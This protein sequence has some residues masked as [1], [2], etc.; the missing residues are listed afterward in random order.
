MPAFSTMSTTVRAGAVE[1][2]FGHD[3]ALSGV[4]GHGSILE[5]DEKLALDHI[6]E[7]I[8]VIVF[9]PVIF[10]V[11]N[12]EANYRGVYLAKRLV[13]PLEL[14]GIGELLF[15]NDLEG[16]VINVQ[17]SFVGIRLRVAHG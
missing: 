15:F 14:A 7:F 4:Q 5:V 9:V 10:A 2:A 17:T 6:E 12:A 3:E 16:R 8:I 11:K 13:V 1:N